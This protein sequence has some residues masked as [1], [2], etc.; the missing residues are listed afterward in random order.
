MRRLKLLLA[1]GLSGPPSVLA[2]TLLTYNVGGNGAEDWSTNAPQVRAIA[3]QMVFLQPDVLTFNEVPFEHSHEMTNFV[4]AF[5]PGYDVAWHS[6]TDGHIRSV[7]LSRFPILREQRWLAR[8][9]LAAFGYDG[10]FTR[11]LFEAEIAVPDYP[12]PLHVFTTHLKSGSDATSA[13]RRAAEANAISNFFVNG[14][15][16]TNAHRAY[17]LTG[18]FNEDVAR[19]RANS[20]DPLGRVANEATGLRLTTP[21]NP[22]TQDDRTFSARAGLTVRYDYILPGGLLFSNVVRSGVFRVSLL[23]PPPPPLLPTD[24]GTASDH[25]PVWMEFANPYPVFAFTE[26]ARRGGE[27]NVT[28]QNHPGAAYVVEA[29]SDLVTWRTLTGGRVPAGPTVS[30]SVPADAPLQ[31]FRIRR[32]Q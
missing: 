12:Q 30:W 7:I 32:T 16:L 2:L 21:I 24:E 26:V 13:A 20:L 28:W 5:L 6:G 29:S 22:M 17:V 31:F 19:P 14:F 27:V 15:L 4:K 8:T 1:L 3:R 9:N 23:D 11:D 18:D 25:L 10:P